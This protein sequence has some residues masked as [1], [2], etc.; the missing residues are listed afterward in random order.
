VLAETVI[1][2][3]ATEAVHKLCMMT[4]LLTSAYAWQCNQLSVKRLEGVQSAC[5]SDLQAV[6]ALRLVLRS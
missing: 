3:A 4:S 2:A 6:V 5:D 1:S